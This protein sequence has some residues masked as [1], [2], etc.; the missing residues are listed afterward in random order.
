VIHSI[1]K[2]LNRSDRPASCYVPSDVHSSYN[3]R[4]AGVCACRLC[5][6]SSQGYCTG[7]YS[8]FSLTSQFSAISR[9][10]S[11]P[12]SLPSYNT[13]VLWM[14]STSSPDFQLSSS[15][16]SLLEGQMQERH[17]SCSESA[18]QPRV[19]RSTALIHQVFAIGYVLVPCVSFHL[20]TFPD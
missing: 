8:R 11:P 15:E 16:S 13:L 20:T 12:A 7:T 14:H 10:F 9:V 19:Q 17:L 4:S 5:T 6:T 18:T 2:C 3:S 1:G